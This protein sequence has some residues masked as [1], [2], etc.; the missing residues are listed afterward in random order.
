MGSFLR[1]LFSF[2]E[3]KPKRSYSQTL[4]KVNGGILALLILLS[5]GLYVDLKLC[6]VDLFVAR[7]AAANSDM[8]MV[9]LSWNSILG[10]INRNEHSYSDYLSSSHAQQ[11]ILFTSSSFQASDLQ[12]EFPRSF[13]YM[14][15]AYLGSESVVEVACGSETDLR[16][17]VDRINKNGTR[18]GK[19]WP[20]GINPAIVASV[21]GS[22]P[23]LFRARKT[24]LIDGDHSKRWGAQ[25]DLVAYAT[26]SGVMLLGI[27]GQ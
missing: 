3:T 14:K 24:E 1:R 15:V 22:L 10:S 7:Q 21:A 27:V 8:G 25:G 20:P 13:K 5:F 26:D 16:V 23:G 6:K 19:T 9:L 2:D 12:I 18:E 4:I 17:V 11:R